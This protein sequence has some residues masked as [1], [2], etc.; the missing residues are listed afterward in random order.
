MHKL[1]QLIN[2]KA[3]FSP[4]PCDFPT[5]LIYYFSMDP[6]CPK[7]QRKELITLPK[8]VKEER[9]YGRGGFDG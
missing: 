3:R 5:T 7:A 9:L 6:K 2:A 4:R 8:E 1:T